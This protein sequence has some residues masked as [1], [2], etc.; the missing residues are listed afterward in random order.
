[1][2]KNSRYNSYF[3]D[4]HPKFV[5]DP[6][7]EDIFMLHFAT[8]KWTDEGASE[9]KWIMIIDINAAVVGAEDDRFKDM[10]RWRL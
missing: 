7:N 10:T 6:E 9:Q 8:L 1:M 4:K 3:L 5:K 2:M